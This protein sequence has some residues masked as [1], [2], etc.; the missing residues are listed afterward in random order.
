MRFIATAVVLAVVLAFT[1]IGI[2]EALAQSVQGS[3]S[4]R[5]VKLRMI[6]V[7]N[8]LD[9]RVVLSSLE[10]GT[11]FVQLAKELSLGPHAERGGHIGTVDV[12]R[13]KPELR[14]ALRGLKPGQH[15]GI[16]VTALGN[17]I[18][19]VTTD[20][21]YENGLGLF[22]RGRYQNAIEEFKKDLEL[23]PDSAFSYFYLGLCQ[24]KLN[25]NREAADSLE[26]A[27]ELAPDLVETHYNLAKVYD[28]LGRT[29]DAELKYLKTIDMDPDFHMA[30]NNLA[31]L[32]AK[33]R[34]KIE[35]GVEHAR[36]AVYLSPTNPIYYH[37]LAMLYMQVEM[38]VE[39]VRALKMASKLSPED[40]YYKEQLKYLEASLKEERGL[41][42][43]KEE[44]AAT[45]K[46]EP[47]QPVI[48]VKPPKRRQQVTRLK[49]L[50][51]KAEK[52]VEKKVEAKK[53]AKVEQKVV[54]GTGLRIKVLNGNG[55]KGA[56]AGIV[57]VLAGFNYQVEE[58][59]NA[60]R[61]D[62]ALTTVFYRKAS[63]KEAIDLAHKIPGTQNVL[64]LR[65]H[66]PFD[67]VI[68]VGLK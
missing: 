45:E 57:E 36:R 53:E 49:E 47:V 61:F 26:M 10:S 37:T 60:E 65:G 68:I 35:E 64:R 19:Q 7:K 13:L 46:R 27:S 8:K 3:G 31:W 34:M 62:W 25:L 48:A 29:Y 32:Y 24:N 22:D 56:A 40:S 15:T 38:K 9:A 50:E 55:I 33:N 39:A 20:E 18:F 41:P 66:E 63:V 21:Y 44:V 1:L 17:A 30:H 42:A 6:V 2:E 12:N 67:I 16:V 5:L 54:K 51:T 11:S 43:T 4:S 23:N 59:G 14:E 58:V 28:S 52:K